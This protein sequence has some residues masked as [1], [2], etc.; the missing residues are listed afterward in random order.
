MSG[1]ILTLLL[2]LVVLAPT[3]LLTAPEVRREETLIVDICSG[4]AP[5]PYDI[6]NPF[7]PGTKRDCGFHQLCMEPLFIVNLATGEYIPWLAESYEYGPDFKTLVVHLRR[8]VKWSD[9]HPFTA[10]DVVFTYELLLKYAPKLL[11]SAAVKKWVEEVRKIDD[12]TVE[13]VLKAP[14]PRFHLTGGVFPVCR[15]WGGVPIVPKH[16]WEGKDPLKFKNY[17]PVGTGPYRLV[18]ASETAFVWE[19][20]DDWW[21]TELFGV[22]PAPKRVIFTAYGP[23]ETKAMKMANHEL[24]QVFMLLPSLFL[25]VKERN[26]YVSSWFKGPPYAW[27]DPCPR[28]LFINHMVYP[29]N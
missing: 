2:A 14:N 5:A 16:I 4:R 24:D 19:R 6:W 20:R 21:G 9:G 11:W 22:R 1:R 12:Y 15:I 10:D 17:P 18:S 7:I 28:H 29:Y 8:G 27:L 13:F 23:P 26:P 3:L 25:S